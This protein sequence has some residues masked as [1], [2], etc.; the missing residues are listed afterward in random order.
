MQNIISYVAVVIFL[1]Y[2]WRN[3]FIFCV[4]VL[5]LFISLREYRSAFEN[6]NE[7]KMICGPYRPMCFQIFRASIPHFLGPRLLKTKLSNKSKSVAKWKW[8]QSFLSRKLVDHNLI[9]LKELYDLINSSCRK[10]KQWLCWW[11]MK[12]VVWSALFPMNYLFLA[13]SLYCPR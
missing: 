2:R 4:L 9:D 13:D 11:G 12:C 7:A 3:N 8:E 6:P 10:N 5:A 1:S